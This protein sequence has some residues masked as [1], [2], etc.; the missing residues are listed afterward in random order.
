MEMK[1]AQLIGAIF[2][3]L[4]VTYYGT[5][6]GAL[7]AKNSVDFG[8]GVVECNL[9]GMIGAR[10]EWHNLLET[11]LLEGCCIVKTKVV[12][13][14]KHTSGCGRYLSGTSIH[15]EVPTLNESVRRI[16]C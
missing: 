10:V 2:S 9:S 6:S 12:S 11:S 3:I 14:T 8:W 16:R 4:E 15:V 13:P 1:S 7:V 5:L